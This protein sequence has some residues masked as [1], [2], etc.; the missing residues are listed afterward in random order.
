MFKCKVCGATEFNF[1]LNPDHKGPAPIV[2]Q[3]EHD[4]VLIRVGER[5]FI[6]DLAFMNQFAVCI[7]GEIRTWEYFYPKVKTAPSP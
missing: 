5:E 4:D 7:C 1:A 6:A 3:N 2:S